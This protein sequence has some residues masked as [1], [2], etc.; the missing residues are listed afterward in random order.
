MVL[1]KSPRHAHCNNV[2]Q[3]H[4]NKVLKNHKNNLAAHDHIVACSFECVSHSCDSKVIALGTC[5]GFI[6]YLI[7]NFCSFVLQ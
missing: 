5:A 2:L 3:S 4:A 6:F 1:F 7:K